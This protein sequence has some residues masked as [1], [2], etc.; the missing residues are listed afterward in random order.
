MGAISAKLLANRLGHTR[1]AT[2]SV[3]ESG[4]SCCM[5]CLPKHAAQVWAV[6]LPVSALPSKL[7]TLAVQTVARCG[8]SSS[9]CNGA[10]IG[11]TWSTP[12]CTEMRPAWQDSPADSSRAAAA[13]VLAKPQTTARQV[14]PIG[15]PPCGH[16][17]PE[18][19][20]KGA[21]PALARHLNC[22]LQPPLL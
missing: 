18:S 5:I 20:Q 22:K 1:Q 15:Q 19:T 16:Y 3:I 21:A 13:G 6:I 10:A 12:M 17:P 11:C 7:Q 8:A 2:A 4:P 9:S 14:L